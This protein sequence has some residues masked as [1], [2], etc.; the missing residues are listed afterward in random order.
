MR[1]WE[2]GS[3][4][5]WVLSFLL[6]LGCTN[7]NEAPLETPQLLTDTAPFV[8]PLDLWDNKISGQ[9][10]LLVRVSELGEVDSVTVATS[11]GFE[12]FDSAAVQGARALK[13]TP[14]RQGERRVAMWTKLPV[15]FVRDTTQM[16]LG[17]E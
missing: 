16:G 13:F 5:A 10:V 2:H 7:Q 6:L 15:R 17:P 1:A 4:G 9:T 14:G 3:M 11:S 12:E 8:Y